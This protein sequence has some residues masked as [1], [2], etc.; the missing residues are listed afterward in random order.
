MKPLCLAIVVALTMPACSR[1][2][3]TGRIDRAYYKQMKQAKIAREKHREQ[4]VARQ[5]AEM[6]PLR[7]SPPP[8]LRETVQSTTENQ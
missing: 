2:T 7:D 1:F 5:R 6:P 4:L 8:L 3:K